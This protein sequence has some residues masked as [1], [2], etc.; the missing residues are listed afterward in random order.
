[1]DNDTVFYLFGAVYGTIV[2]LELWHQK[3]MTNDGLFWSVLVAL[4]FPYFWGKDEEAD[5]AIDDDERRWLKLPNYS[6]MQYD[7]V[8][9]MRRWANRKARRDL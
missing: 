2:C 6:G 4:A 5:R 7:S 3:T 1:M 8:F 9:T